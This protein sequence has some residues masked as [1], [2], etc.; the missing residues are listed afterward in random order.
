MFLTSAHPSKLISLSFRLRLQTLLD[1]ADYVSS[2]GLA[3]LRSVTF[4]LHRLG[5][6]LYLQVKY[7]NTGKQ[8][9]N[10]SIRTEKE[11]AGIPTWDFS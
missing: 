5:L 7:Q 9:Y 8:G 11:T 10:R 3:A 1:V 6:R 4:G 2:I